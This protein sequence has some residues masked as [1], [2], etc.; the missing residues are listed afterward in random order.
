M[1]NKNMQHDFFLSITFAQMSTSKKI[2]S[3]QE[4]GEFGLIDRITKKI[5]SYQESTILGPSD[6]A[7]IVAHEKN[8]L[9][10]SDLLIE[11]IHFDMTYTPLKHLGYKSVVVNLSDIYAMNAKPK[12]I[13]VSL[14]FSSKYTLEAIDELYD[15]ILLACKKYNVDIIG[16]DI[17]SSPFGLIISVTALGENDENNIVKRSGAKENDLIVVS[18]DLGGAYLGL[19]ILQREKEVWKSDPNMQ[20]ELDDFNY[21]LQRQLKP[22]AREDV[23]QYLEKN[24]IKP[25][26]MIDIS[27]GLASEI[28]HLC[29]Q[30]E[31]GCQ[32]Y[33]EKIPI[34]QQ[35]YNT[36]MDFNLNP[37]TC[38]LNGGEDY[39]LLF[40]INQKDFELVSKNTAL[41][42]IG[43]ITKKESGYNLIG[44]GDTSIPITAQGWS[45]L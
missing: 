41:S 39:E 33:E 32:L 38:A 16:G 29:K 18:G 6:D 28:L 22:E 11:G 10:S 37:S 20:P 5:K 24:K 30:S 15:G 9:V 27:D 35:T 31:V 44:H 40:T 17:S 3:L 26:S 7:G 19:T 8:T 12:Q 21:I 43:H 2:E 45:H 34:D 42:I 4:L 14:G 1:L 36:A 13:T 23:I 25:T